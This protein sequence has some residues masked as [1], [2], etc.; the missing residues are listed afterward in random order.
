MKP[1][2][3]I[4]LFLV[5]IILGVEVFTEL[6]PQTDTI[7][8]TEESILLRDIIVHSLNNNELKVNDIY[9]IEEKDTPPIRLL[10]LVE[11]NA[12]VFR[13]SGESCNVCI[14]FVI[15]S[16]KESFPDYTTNSA[17]IL[18]GSNINRRVLKGYYGKNVFPISGEE[19]GLPAE[20][21]NL[22]CLFILDKSGT[23]HMSFIPDKAFPEL[24]QIYLKTI[25][26]RFF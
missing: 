12:L 7:D 19:L 20:E 26:D 8:Q 18:L 11:G 9:I 16:L 22:P 13:F 6:K 4:I 2:L 15:N 1:I 23:T 10:D 24:T 17:I 25:I 14:E 3:I 21:Y 5:L